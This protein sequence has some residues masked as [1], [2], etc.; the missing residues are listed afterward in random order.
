MQMNVGIYSI[1][2][3]NW[4]IHILKQ[5]QVTLDNAPTTLMAVPAMNEPTVKMERGNVWGEVKAL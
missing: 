2:R 3:T 4:S 1:Y 5:F